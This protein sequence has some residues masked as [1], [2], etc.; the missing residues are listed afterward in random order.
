MS[1]ILVLDNNMTNTLLSNQIYES[2][3]TKESIPGEFET[4]NAKILA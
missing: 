4:R 2:Y 3:K 1:T